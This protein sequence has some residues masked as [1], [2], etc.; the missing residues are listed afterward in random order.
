MDDQICL[1]GYI[2]WATIVCSG[3]HYKI[4]Y[5]RWLKQ[6]KLISHRS[7]GWKYKIKA[8]L[9]SGES[10]LPDLQMAA[11]LC[12]HMAE[13]EKDLCLSSSSQKVRVLSD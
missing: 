8:D 2:L 5:A 12:P 11:L 4:P 7:G 6:Q 1:A 3:C 9:V 13:R 10:F